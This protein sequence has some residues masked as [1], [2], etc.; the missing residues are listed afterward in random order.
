M[1][2]ELMDKLEKIGF[3]VY[4]IRDDN[5]IELYKDS[6]EEYKI[7]ID[8]VDDN[9]YAIER[10]IPL[11]ELNE[12]YTDVPE[13]TLYKLKNGRYAI[14]EISLSGASIKEI[15]SEIN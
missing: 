7:L 4:Y 10:E 9:G 13:I 5:S 8:I 12:M 2:K 1:F 11:E 6:V 15:L 14:K 3:E